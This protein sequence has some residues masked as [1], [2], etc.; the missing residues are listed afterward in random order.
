MRKIEALLPQ[1]RSRKN[2]SMFGTNWQA[3]LY[4]ANI[5]ERLRDGASERAGEQPDLLDH[6]G[7]G[8]LRELGSTIPAAAV[9]GEREARGERAEGDGRHGTAEHHEA[10]RGPE[11]EERGLDGDELGGLDLVESRLHH[12]LQFW[13]LNPRSPM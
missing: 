10:E 2:F 1:A 6:P 5:E 9:G 12:C 13:Q 11:D 8:L 7:P 4:E 3:E